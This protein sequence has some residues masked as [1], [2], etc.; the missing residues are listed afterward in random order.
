M[1]PL[2]GVFKCAEKRALCARLIKFGFRIPRKSFRQF[3]NKDGVWES[4][5]GRG[6]GV[7]SMPNF[8]Q[9]RYPLTPLKHSDIR[10]WGLSKPHKLSHEQEGNMTHEEKEARMRALD[11]VFKRIEAE[12]KAKIKAAED[13]V[14]R[15]IAYWE[16]YGDKPLDRSKF[17]GL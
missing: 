5:V 8:I 2:S 14:R 4:A 9:A 3:G 1:E 13:R 12:E 17:Y 7:W 16:R 15:Y 10:L 11:A 6:F